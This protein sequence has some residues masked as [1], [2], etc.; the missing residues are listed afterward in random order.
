M[1]LRS[2][3]VQ[4][5]SLSLSVISGLTQLF[6]ID[7]AVSHLHEYELVLKQRNKSPP[8]S[9]ASLLKAL[10]MCLVVTGNWGRR[11]EAR[12]LVID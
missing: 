1:C 6:S 10:K 5:E 8:G 3:N 2:H 11:D 9:S 7:F 4:T 12:Q